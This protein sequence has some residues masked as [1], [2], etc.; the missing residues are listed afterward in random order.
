M[1]TLF[2]DTDLISVYTRQDAINDGV[3]VDVTA[4]AREAG[5]KFPTAVTRALW[6]S[7]V[8]PDKY[9]IR[10]GESAEGRLWD[11]VYILRT[12]MA[13]NTGSVINY[14][15]LATSGGHR[16]RVNLKSVCGPGDNAEP[17]ITIML[18][19]ED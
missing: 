1:K 6:D 16:K 3:L 15:I 4:T 13:G 19:D 12:L 2:E 5:I 18:P 11:V 7:V 8:T 14:L 10:H 17:V 9:A